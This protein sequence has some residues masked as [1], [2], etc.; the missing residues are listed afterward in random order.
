MKKCSLFVMLIFATHA[1]FA[2]ET[3]KYQGVSSDNKLA[4]T[5]NL[6]QDASSI[7]FDNGVV[8]C[9]EAFKILKKIEDHENGQ[10]TFDFGHYEINTD[11]GS[12]LLVDV[13]SDLFKFEEKNAKESGSFQLTNEGS[14]KV[15]FLVKTPQENFQ[16]DLTKK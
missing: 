16:L 11:D 9:T 1:S 5:M 6:V 12:T 15:N 13:S 14:G 10:L 2:F 4:C 7:T 3:G 8:N